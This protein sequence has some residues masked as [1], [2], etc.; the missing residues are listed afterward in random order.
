MFKTLFIAGML[1]GF[2]SVL[3]AAGFYPWIDHP[4]LVSRTQVQPN[5]GRREDFLIRLPVDQIASVGTDDLG[6][7]ALS[8]PAGL[9]LPARLATSPLNLDQFKVRDADG[10]VIGI[11]SRHAVTVE[12]GAAVSWS[13]T[14]PS[15][16]TIWL[17]GQLDPAQIDAVF[18]GVNYQPGESWSGDIQVALNGAGDGSSGR[19]RGGSDEF[20]PLT[21]SYV[22][23]WRLT[24]I[25]DSGELTGTIEINT[26]TYLV[27]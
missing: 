6:F 21:G 10:S 25:S 1:L 7:G 17:T 11:A 14:V 20:E 16:G 2:G 24:G 13:I 19:V 18:T 27:P 3:A 5:G 9:E 4:R 23:R 12:G 22:E 26:T 15:R 8:I